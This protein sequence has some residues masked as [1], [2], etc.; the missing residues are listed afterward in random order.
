MLKK[1][2]VALS[3]SLRSGLRMRALP[4]PLSMKVWLTAIKMVSMAIMP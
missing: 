3:A 2:T 4:N 1:N